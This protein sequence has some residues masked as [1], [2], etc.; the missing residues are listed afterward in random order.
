LQAIL[1]GVNLQFPRQVSCCD[2]G[3]PAALKLLVIICTL[4][5][6]VIFF[7]LRF[8]EVAWEICWVNAHKGPQSN[9]MR[10]LISA[11]ISVSKLN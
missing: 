7:G 10:W 11:K 4:S 5:N 8:S 2:R 9:R 1:V 6:P 3:A